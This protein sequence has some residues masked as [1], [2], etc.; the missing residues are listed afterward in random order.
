MNGQT[1]SGPRYFSRQTL[2]DLWPEPV[3]VNARERLRVCAGALAGLLVVG[4]L[5]LLAARAAGISPW[6]VAPLGASAVL[7]FATPGGPMAQPWP[8]LGGNVLSSLV[9]VACAHLPLPLPLSAAL[10]VALALALMFATRSL[11]PP[12]GAAALLAVLAGETAWSYALFP[13]A[14]NCVLLVLC[15]A[16]FNSLTGRRYPHPRQVAETIAGARFSTADLD[17]ALAHY[18]QYLDVSRHDLA[19][20]LHHAESV[21]YQR[22]LGDLRCADVMTRELVTADYAMPLGEAWGLMRRKRI[23]ALPVVDPARRIAGIV[24]AGDFLKLANLD[25]T[26]GIGARLRALLRPSGATHSDRAEVVG[27]V[28]TRRVQVISAERPLLELLPLLATA[29]H[30]HI[31]II[32]AERRLVGIITQTDLV[33]ALHRAVA[34]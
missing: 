14:L 27:Q 21:A 2:R 10:A 24:T 31:P 8:V 15:G 9:G 33:R 16:L 23:K 29:G 5:G 28:M 7:V 11:H 30:H 22:Q 26:P 25:A 17:T 19:E 20:L 12:G 3:R 34:R 13:V 1:P 6:L 18:N 4:L 32:D